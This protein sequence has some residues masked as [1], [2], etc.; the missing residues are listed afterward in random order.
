VAWR[1]EVKYTEYLRHRLEHDEEFYKHWP[2]RVHGTDTYG[3]I[4][5]SVPACHIDVDKLLEFDQCVTRRR[6]CPLA[7]VS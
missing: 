5:I 6:E 2:E 1:Q 4:L 3:H 7:S